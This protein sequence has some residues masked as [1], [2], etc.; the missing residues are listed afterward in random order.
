[1]TMPL[2]RYGLRQFLRTWDGVNP[3]SSC[4]VTACAIIWV[5]NKNE[6]RG[7]TDQWPCSCK[8]TGKDSSIEL[9]Y[10]TSPSHY[11][12][13]CCHQWGLVAFTW[14][15]FQ[16]KYSRHL[17]L[18]CVWKLMVNELS[19]IMAYWI[20]WDTGSTVI[21]FR[22]PTSNWWVSARKILSHCYCTGVT[23]FLY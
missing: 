18:I 13:Q 4:G 22:T 2:Y 7:P 3:S 17:L 5:P 11:L 6:W 10:L 23:S 12:N 19:N 8:S 16:R 14:G 1:M 9:E 20:M 15:Q 21:L